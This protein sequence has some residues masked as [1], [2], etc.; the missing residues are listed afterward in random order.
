[1]PSMRRVFRKN[2]AQGGRH[3]KTV[4]GLMRCLVGILHQLEGMGGDW[5]FRWLSEKKEG[6]RN[7]KK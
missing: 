5:V 2:D 1:M 6:S 4:I 7:S 3:G